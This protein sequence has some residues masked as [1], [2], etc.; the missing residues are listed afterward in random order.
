[1]KATV[2]RRNWIFHSVVKTKTLNTTLT[3]KET[4]HAPT[5]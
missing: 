1:M 3:K 2:K 5:K 4:H